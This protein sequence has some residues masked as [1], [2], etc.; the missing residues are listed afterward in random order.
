[1]P[2]RRWRVGASVGAMQTTLR[3]RGR[4]VE[5]SMLSATATVGYH[6]GP[7]YGIS[8]GIGAVIDGEIDSGI[9]GPGEIGPGVIAS[10]SA[11][12]LALFEKPRRPFLLFTGSASV[13]M[14]TAESDDGVS[15]DL[16]A[17]DLRVGVMVGKSFGRVV[18]YAAA[19][20][21]GGPVF[22]TI[23]GND[24]TGTDDHRYTVGGGASLRIATQVNG[25][26]ELMPLGEMSGSAGVSL[27]F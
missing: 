26:V 24:V 20:L 15:K 23:R 9:N 18:P 13:S 6:P 27:S 5:L 22:W 19:R 14:A 7:R 17:S 25:F 16:T 3:L 8:F 21:F 10:A 11:T 12:Y 1:M 2:E 4:P